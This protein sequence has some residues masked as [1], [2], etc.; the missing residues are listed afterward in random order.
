MMCQ[1]IPIKNLCSSQAKL[2][3][4]GLLPQV[5]SIL[6]ESGCKPKTDI[7]MDIM[8]LSKESVSDSRDT[9]NNQM[10]VK[11]DDAC[12]TLGI[13]ADCQPFLKLKDGGGIMRNSQGKK[14]IFARKL[15]NTEAYHYRYAFI[16]RV[17]DI[18]YSS[19]DEG[20]PL[21]D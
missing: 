5:G 3:N 2:N 19:H 16:N 18:R 8:G 9:L 4:Y 14:L 12:R 17:S 10:I 21:S 6:S 20:V 13:S 15:F 1:F 11:Y 7:F